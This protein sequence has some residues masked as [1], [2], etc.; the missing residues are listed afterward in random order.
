M[1]LYVA[2]ALSPGMLYPSPDRYSTISYR[3]VDYDQI[4]ALVGRYT[5]NIFMSDRVSR[6]SRKIV[7]E[8]LRLDDAP[9]PCGPFYVSDGD[10][11]VVRY[12]G[13][14]VPDIAAP[15]DTSKFHYVHITSH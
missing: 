2:N 11:L 12:I 15:L 10:V 8:G 13:P 7:M 4:A 14:K 6:W 9:R 5:G 1:R 3:M